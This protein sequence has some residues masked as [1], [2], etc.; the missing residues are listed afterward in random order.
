MLRRIGVDGATSVTNRS[1]D[2]W[3][4]LPGICRTALI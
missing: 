2:T 1:L 3:E 4:G